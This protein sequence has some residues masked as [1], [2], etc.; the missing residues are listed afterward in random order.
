MILD[1]NIQ[2]WNPIQTNGEKE[3]IMMNTTTTTNTSATTTTT[4][5]VYTNVDE[6]GNII[7]S[8]IPDYDETREYIHT[9]IGKSSSVEE[10]FIKKTIR[11]YGAA[12]PE[13]LMKEAEKEA[14]LQQE[15]ELAKNQYK[16]ACKIAGIETEED[17]ASADKRRELIKIVA[18]CVAVASIF[19]AG[20]LSAKNFNKK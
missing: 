2:Y 4:S 1:R 15:V 14:Q 18:D 17:R 3:F 9:H 11:H 6:L 19:F 5:K 12:T 10:D 13:N 20:V 8:Q 7:I 16:S